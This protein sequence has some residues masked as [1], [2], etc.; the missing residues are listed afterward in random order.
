MGRRL[1]M[2]M[3]THVPTCPERTMIDLGADP[4]AVLGAHEADG[5]VVVRTYRPDAERV[6][7][8]PAGVEAE[9]RD[10]AGLWEAL[11]P[12]AALPLE[13]ELEVEYPSGSTFRLRDP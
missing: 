3:C 4:H 13:Y 8:Q 2:H 6:L 1:H 7:V 5:G 9:L 12:G 10:P 11:L